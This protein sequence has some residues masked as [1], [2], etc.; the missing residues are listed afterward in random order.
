MLNPKVFIQKARS[1]IAENPKRAKF[2][3]LIA[4]LVLLPLI[5]VTAL[6]VQNLKQKASESDVIRI[7]DASGNPIASTTDPNVFIDINLPP[8]W[9]LPG[10]PS[11]MNNLVRKAYAVGQSCANIGRNLC[12]SGE[13]C[14]YNSCDDEGNCTGTCQPNQNQQGDYSQVPVNTPT[15]TRAMAPTSVPQQP[16]SIQNQIPTYNP[17]NNN[18]NP[19]SGTV[20]NQTPSI[21]ILK[22]IIM[23]TTGYPSFSV[24]GIV[25]ADGTTMTDVIRNNKTFPFSLKLLDPSENSAQRRVDT[26]LIAEDGFQLTLSATIILKRAPGAISAPVSFTAPVANPKSFSKYDLNRDDT[27]NCKDAKILI[28]QYGKR[29][30]GN[31]SDLNFDGTVDSTDYNIIIRSFTP[32]DST[33]CEQ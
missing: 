14:T 10:Q 5:I 18:S 32:G 8:D 13:S 23:A 22:S 2:I 9:V 31:S 33:V 19:V 27:V 12:P 20:N 28:G 15:P 16:T 21:H 25:N 4:I 26:T 17:I 29:I 11:T 1:F 30:A 24:S 7:T 6:T 3:G